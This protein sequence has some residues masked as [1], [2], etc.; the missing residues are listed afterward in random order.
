[1][2]ATTCLVIMAPTLHYT[3]I[4][5]LLEPI[6]GSHVKEP[7]PSSSG[8]PHQ[9][10]GCSALQAVDRPEVEFTEDE[11]AKGTSFRLLDL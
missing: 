5:T 11:R 10:N 1:M 4:V 3:L 7:Y 8:S 2:K 9:D 6:N